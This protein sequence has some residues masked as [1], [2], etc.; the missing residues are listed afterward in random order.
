MEYSDTQVLLIQNFSN[1]KSL[2][3]EIVKYQ[4]SNDVWGFSWNGQRK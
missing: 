1:Y 3:V 4:E 2:D